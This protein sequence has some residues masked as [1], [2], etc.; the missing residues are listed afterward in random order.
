[1]E[2]VREAEKAIPVVRDVDVVV[3]GGGCSGVFA[4]LSAAKRGARTLLIERFGVL[5]GNAGPGMIYGCVDPF[6]EAPLLVFDGAK[7]LAAEMQRRIEARRPERPFVRP[8]FAA[9]FSDV[10]MRMAE[11]YGLDLMLSAYAADPIVE[12]GVCKGLFVETKSG[13]VAV[14]AKVV[15]D[16]TA[17]ADLARR[18]GAPFVRWAPLDP[19]FAPAIRERCCREPYSNWNEVGL[20]FLVSGIN[21]QAYEQF[22]GDAKAARLQD[23]PW[24]P[25]VGI[26]NDVNPQCPLRLLPAMREEWEAGSYCFAREIRHGAG[27]FWQ[28]NM[29]CP[30][31]GFVRIGQDAGEGTTII[32]GDLDVSDWEQMTLAERALRR[33]AYDTLEFMRRR[34][35]GW[36]DA[37]MLFTAPFIGSRGGPYIE[38]EYTVT[39][40]DI[41]TGAR[42]EDAVIRVIWEAR[43]REIL[44]SPKA[45]PLTES[46]YDV[47]Y[48]MMLPKGIDNLLVVG[49]G[50]SYVRRGHDPATRARG[51]QYRLGEIAGIAATMA[52][53]PCQGTRTLNVKDLQ[54]RLIAEGLTFGETDRFRELGLLGEE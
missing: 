37:W 22:V 23:V 15:I 52:I 41:V 16:A 21:W 30:H 31:Y 36:A 42:H 4:G 14:R 27:L 39:P 25:P 13:R 18:A 48:R 19:E 54:R 40:E 11:E 7:G 38:G 45:T 43:Q 2:S 5:G 44:D 24:T 29:N 26:V 51:V 32:H 10:A 50:S 49:R 33:H 9:L 17:E 20:V 8:V 53:A 12:A 28:P 1:M 35:P 46:G 6:A 47:P 34:A 3:A